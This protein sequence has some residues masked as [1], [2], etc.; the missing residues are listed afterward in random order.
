MKEGLKNIIVNEL[1]Y[2]IVLFPLWWFLGVEQF[3]W[4]VSVG[5]VFMQFLIY[6]KF[7]FRA[8]IISI[9]LLLFLVVYGISFF[10]IVEKMRYITYFR[11]LST[12]ITA[13]MLL[14]ISW[15]VIDK[16]SQIE[17]LLKAIVLV[18]CINSWCVSFFI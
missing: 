13:L 18:Y 9:L 16:W 7:E 4:F 3:F 6:S 2:L 12:Y 8:N 1:Y 14:I 17:K 11:N 10:S 15:N 5:L